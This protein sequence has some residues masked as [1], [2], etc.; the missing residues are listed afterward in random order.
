MTDVY[1]AGESSISIKEVNELVY[2]RIEQIAKTVSKCL[3]N[4]ELDFRSMPI[5]LTGG[6]ITY[7]RGVNEILAD[8][9]EKPVET[10]S[11]SIPQL[12]KP[13]LSSTLGL[14][15]EVLSVQEKKKF[16]FVDFLKKKFYNE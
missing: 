10:L 6:G 16:S 14:I 2:A 3:K 8:V 4:N 1:K 15:N 9:F 5:Y 13:H 7:L 12:D 11:S